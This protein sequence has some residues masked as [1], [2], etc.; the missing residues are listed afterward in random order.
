MGTSTEKAV[1][2]IYLEAVI[3]NE[4]PKTSMSSLNSLIIGL[5][6]ECV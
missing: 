1:D 3:T 5:S 6:G 2:F 4:T